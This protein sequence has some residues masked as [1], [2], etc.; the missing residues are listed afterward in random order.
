MNQEIKKSCNQVNLVKSRFRQLGNYIRQVNNRNTDLKVSRLLGLSMTKEFRET[1]SNTVGTDMSVYK[2]MYKYQ[3]ACDFMS[4]IRVSKLP[5]VLKLDDEPNLVSPAYPVFE[6]KDINE[7]DPEYLMMWFR[8]TEFDRYATFKCDAA[9]RGGFDWQELCETLIPI[10]QITCQREIVAQYNAVQNRIN[11]NNQLISCL[12]QTAQAIYKEWFVN[13][14]DVNGK[15]EDLGEIVTGKTP[16]T[17]DERNFGTHMPFITIPD[18]HSYVFAIKTE[19]C[20]SE[21]GVRLQQNKT[22]PPYTVCVSCIGTSGLVTITT[23]PSQTNQ[24][25]NSIIS[26]HGIGAF[27][28]Y[29]KMIELKDTINSWGEKG[30]VGNNLNKQ[31]FSSIPVTIPDKQLDE[32]FEK[33][34]SPIFEMIKLK[35][36]ES[37]K[38]EQLKGLLLSRM[39]DCDLCD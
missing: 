22:L 12:E 17:N 18:M 16:P 2:V 3:F 23:E 39:S 36:Q 5:V 11:Q 7:L 38:L 30:S 6:I 20:L 10:P 26:N 21:Q 1:T 13:G 25:I 24:Q 8:R 27:Y 29:F 15:I 35:I 37:Q 34:V 28:T 33:T 31:E 19:R 9:I 4:P 32:K 14:V